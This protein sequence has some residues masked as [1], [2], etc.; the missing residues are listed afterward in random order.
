MGNLINDGA[1]MGQ[2][3]IHIVVSRRD[4]GFAARRDIAIL[5]KGAHIRG[6]AAYFVAGE[7]VVKT[8]E[9]RSVEVNADDILA[10]G[11]GAIG[12]ASPEPS[13]ADDQCFVPKGHMRNYKRPYPARQC[14]SANP[15]TEQ[16]GIQNLADIIMDHILEVSIKGRFLQIDE[17]RRSLKL[18]DEARGGINIERRPAHDEE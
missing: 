16:K 2:K 5:L 9:R 17:K 1:N 14:A 7:S 13:A 18:M 6:I 4:D 3:E 11:G 10:F 8:A 12:D 15:L